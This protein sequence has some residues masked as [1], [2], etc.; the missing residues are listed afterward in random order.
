MLP[1]FDEV[2][3]FSSA[4]KPDLLVFCETWLSQAVDDDF[5]SIPDYSR[6]IRHDRALKRGGGVCLFSKVGVSCRE[7][8]CLAQPPSWIECVWVA[9]HASKIVLLALYVPPNLN[10]EEIKAV[11]DY[12]TTQAD[13]A[14]N[15]VPESKLMIIG[16]LNHLPTSDLESTFGLYQTVLSPTRGEAIL[17]KVLMEQDLLESY[18]SPIVGANFGK[19][20]HLSVFVKPKR[21]RT[22]AV[23]I[24]KV[25]DFRESN[26]NTFLDNLKNKSWH[27]IYTSGESLDTKCDIFY[28]MFRQAHDSIPYCY[29]E[30]TP[31]DKPWI[32]PLLKHLINC[33]Y[34]AFR[35]RQF[36]KY[37]HL[38]LKVKAEMTKAKTLW[39]ESLKKSPGGIW[40]AVR[41][42]ASGKKSCSIPS[43]YENCSFTEVA[44]EL[45]EVFSSVFN[46]ED[47]T[48]IEPF[49]STSN[50][51]WKVDIEVGVISNMLATL[52]PSKSTGSDNL[53]ARLL[54]IGHDIL[55]G[56]LAHIYSLSLSTGTVPN[57]WKIANVAPIPKI[58]KPS[59]TDFRPVSLLPIPAK[60]LESL[61]LKSVKSKLID[62]YGSNQYGFRPASSTFNAHLAIHD[63][64]T[65]QLD[66]PDII[67][68]AMIAL[69]VSKAF[70]R[71]LHSKIMQSLAMNGF[72]RTFVLWMQDFLSHRT[73]R[74]IFQGNASTTEKKVTSGVPQGSVLAP[75]L[76]AAHVGAVRTVYPFTALIKYADDFTFLIPCLRSNEENF[77]KFAKAEIENV[78]SW[79]DEQGLKINDAK[80]KTVFFS[81]KKPSQQI[82]QSL[83]NFVPFLN[84]LGVTFQENLK[85]DTHV[86]NKAKA[87]ANRVNVLRYLKRLPNVEKKDLMEVYLNYI[88]TTLE[89]NA[90]LFV[91]MN[92]KNNDTLERIRRRCHRII[93]GYGCHCDDFESIST[94]RQ[95]HAHKAFNKIMHAENIS[96]DLLPHFLPRSGLF[97][98]EFM[99]TDRRARSFVPY[100]VLKWNSSHFYGDK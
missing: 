47:Q 18:H 32:T 84:I 37:R 80:T 31:W 93:C 52:K 77:I 68:V 65:R 100:C 63:F 17:D 76:F 66:S 87:V 74:V 94:R 29:V 10:S 73:Q 16:D 59:I 78:K 5:I 96:H 44:N 45:N 9:I 82:T 48:D 81:K 11:T 51:E 39:I 7:I 34:E 49:F 20:D 3:A 15:C 1:K 92:Q 14:L 33:R 83:P 61:V 30:M 55:A 58:S 43:E 46:T 6:V 21:E 50:G 42:T 23:Q 36:G 86:R 53:P 90:P 38:K 28:D 13:T 99:K 91:G 2:C 88:L 71:L 56:P 19:S 95:K 4:Q 24:K 12:I 8:T 62:Q 67:G 27:K 57:K 22:E 35:S 25:Y 26:M 70:D 64:V 54:K 79:C 98:Q 40:K 75:F 97:F 41:S 69:D 89:Y 85:W 60:I 72:P